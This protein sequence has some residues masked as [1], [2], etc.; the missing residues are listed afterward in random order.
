MIH[1][2]ERCGGCNCREADTYH[3]SYGHVIRRERLCRLHLEVVSS[4]PVAEVLGR[5][6]TRKAEERVGALLRSTGFIIPL[7]TEA[8]S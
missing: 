2:P 4:S 5:V 7:G 6:G 1:T 8:A 3:V